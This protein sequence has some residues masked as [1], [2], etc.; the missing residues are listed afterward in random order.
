MPH[1]KLAI[2]GFGNVGK[3]LARLLQ[4]KQTELAQS[5]GFTFS[6]TGIA[7][8][9]HGMAI[10][11]AGL[12]LE[13]VLTQDLV[14]LS[15]QPAPADSLDFIRRCGA[16]VLFEISPV[17]YRTGQPALDHL[18]LALELGMYA[19]TANKGPV[20]HGYR[21]LTEL[22]QQHGRKFFFESSVMDGAPIFALFRSA[23]PA[24]RLLAFRGVLNSTTNLILSLMESGQSFDAAVARAQELGMAETDPS[25]DIDGWDASVKIAA[26]ATVL[27]G[28]PLKPEAVNRQGIR[29]ITPQDI[30]RAKQQGKRW[31]LICSA[32][33]SGNLLTA[34]V[35][36]EMVASDSPFFS[37]DGTTSIVQF[38]TDVLSQLSV[39]EGNP[40][41]RTTAYG[42]MA[43]LINAVR[44]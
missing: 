9:H 23:L 12:D 36:P 18:R 38:E 43:D 8:A 40:T 15:T 3:A 34:T 44:S 4:E 42:L 16:D 26:L 29:S 24:A 19:I 7:T 17:N 31:K 10:D 37:I 41:P 11:P 22:A 21:E 32:R 39:I 20:V 2:L 30:E 6:V 14:T 13:K 27:M 1:Y 33:R 5:Y 35:A 25:G 28:M